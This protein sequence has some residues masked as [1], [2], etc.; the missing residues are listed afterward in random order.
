M[1]K[2]SRRDFLKYS[3]VGLSSVLLAAC[4]WQKTPTL[5]SPL[6]AA[7]RPPVQSPTTVTV[8]PKP[9][10]KNS[11]PGPAATLAKANTTIILGRPTST[12]ITANLV[13]AVP[14]EIHY[15]YG[16]ASGVYTARTAAQNAAAGVPI[17]TQIDGLQPNTRYYYKVIAS[18]MPS[19]EHSFQTQRAPGSPSRSRS[20]PTR[21]TVNPISMARSMP[22]P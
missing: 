7:T 3:A 1:L 14:A 11:T 5:N 20:R 17:E 15:E 9:K 16:T 22:Q 19:E 10:G 21:T 4:D 18:G 12:A 6:P 2:T 8:T 13:S